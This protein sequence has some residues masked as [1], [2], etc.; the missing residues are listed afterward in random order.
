MGFRLFYDSQKSSWIASIRDDFE[1]PSIDL[2][3]DAQSTTKFETVADTEL[4]Q[5]FNDLRQNDSVA[6]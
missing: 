2:I 3:N 5:I 1:D 6:E 4:R